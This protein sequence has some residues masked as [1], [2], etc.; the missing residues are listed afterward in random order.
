LIDQFPEGGEAG[1]FG[2]TV[3]EDN[4]DVGQ[5]EAGDEHVPH[6]PAGRGVPEETVAGTQIEMERERL[7]V[8]E[9]D[10]AVALDDGL[11]NAGRAGGVENPERMLK[12]HRFKF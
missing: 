12:R 9:E 1:I 10:A 8:F 11:G 2:A 4:G 5:Q 6:H 7:E 3:V